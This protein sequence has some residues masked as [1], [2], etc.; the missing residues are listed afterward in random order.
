MLPN[1]LNSRVLNKYTVDS[2]DALRTSTGRNSANA[3]KVPGVDALPG[4]STWNS[5]TRTVTLLGLITSVAD[6]DF[7]DT[8][9][10]VGAGA[11]IGSITQCLFGEEASGRGFSFYLNGDITARVGKIANCTMKGA[12]GS[13]ATAGAFINCAVSSNTGGV[14][15]TNF[16]ID[17]I[18][19]NNFDA[20]YSDVL[21]LS[22]SLHRNGQ[23]VQNNYFGRPQ[24]LPNTPTAYDTITTYALNFAVYD[25]TDGYKY[26]SKVA[27]NVNNPLPAKT[28]GTP[29]LNSNTWWQ[30]V[31]PHSDAITTTASI[32]RISI[33]N[34]LADWGTKK[35]GSLDIGNQAGVNNFV[36]LVR[37]TNSD[38][39]FNSVTIEGNKVTTGATTSAYLIEA[40]AGGQANYNGPITF[41]DLKSQG[42]SLNSLFHPNTNSNVA[43]WI[44]ARNLK[45]APWTAP[46]GATTADAAAA[47]VNTVLPVVSGTT[48][49]GA[50]LTTTIGTFTGFPTPF[51]NIKWQRS[52]NGTTG[53]A[54]IAGSADSLTYL[55]GVVDEG[56]YVRSVI[57]AYNSSS[58]GVAANSAATAQIA[59]GYVQKT[60]STNG[61]A[62]TGITPIGTATKFEFS[63][64][65]KPSLT[66]TGRFLRAA[67]GVDI[68]TSATG[69]LNVLFFDS[70]G[71]AVYAATSPV[72]AI[73]ALAK[74]HLYVAADWSTGSPTVVVR[75]N[76]TLITMTPTVGPIVGNGSL[77]PARAH[78]MF[79]TAT[80]ILNAEFSDYY[81]AYHSAAMQGYAAFYNGG[82]PPSLTGVGSPQLRWG[83]TQTAANLNAGQNLG[84]GGTVTVTTGTFTDV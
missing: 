23:I 3:L 13:Y 73:S 25:T 19:N 38:N 74:Q 5:G 76:G 24:N 46:T 17:V 65:V 27:G 59:V 54:D 36:R 33:L 70:A 4:T 80:T 40:S 37:N 34:N 58:A 52:A 1:V 50:T 53:W 10:Y 48:T 9:V 31:D 42:N 66:V 6:W 75:I 69:V 81:F 79:R 20:P 78:E 39:L 16:R 41:R 21:K 49:S 12:G 7:R 67:N 64:W 28:G 11:V 30:G 22:G 26:L 77:R 68:Y 18:D 61:T 8:T 2:Q 14:G 84:G 60:Y 62:N 55:I 51:T 83:G 72:G 63:T 35:F 45:N 82:T 71:T 15:V 32:G 57:T 47:P 56:Q 29:K 44:N 43:Y